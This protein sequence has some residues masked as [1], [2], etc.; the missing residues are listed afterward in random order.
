MIVAS[1]DA[2][3]NLR[4]PIFFENEAPPKD[5]WEYV[6]RKDREIGKLHEDIGR[7]SARIEQLEQELAEMREFPPAE[8]QE[9]AVSSRPVLQ[10]T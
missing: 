1:E 10:K 2:D 3:Q 7:L 5:M 6:H 9:S 4:E 8:S